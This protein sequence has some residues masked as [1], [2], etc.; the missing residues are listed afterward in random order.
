MRSRST[1]FSEP[2]RPRIRALRALCGSNRLLIALV[3]AATASSAVLAQSARVPRTR[4]GKPD[5]RGT[6]Y[7]GGNPGPTLTHTNIIEAHA[8][9]F[10]LTAGRSPIV[11]PADG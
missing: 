2:R 6:W 10:G 7:P 11:D 8:G 4:D 1:R 9:G 5:L 3:F